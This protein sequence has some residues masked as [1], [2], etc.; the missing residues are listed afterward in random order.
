MR[1]V[2]A[3]TERARGELEASPST[4]GNEWR[5]LFLGAVDVGGDEHAVPMDKLRSIGIIDDLDAD[6]LTRAHAE[7]GAGGGAV[8]TDGRENVGAVQFDGDGRD[9]KGVVGRSLGGLGG[10]RWSGSECPGDPGGEARDG[11]VRQGQAAELEEIAPIQSN[12]TARGTGPACMVSCKERK[13][14][15][16]RGNGVTATN[17]AFSSSK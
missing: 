14:Q 5:T 12:V 1:M 11:S 17:G 3:A 13:G 15:G 9:A 8:V 2:P 4:R 16:A 7:Y 6:P 10:Q